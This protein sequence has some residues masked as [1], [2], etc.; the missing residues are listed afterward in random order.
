MPPEL[1]PLKRTEAPLLLVM[2]ELPAVAVDENCTVRASL[3]VALAAVLEPVNPITPPVIAIVPADV[4]LLKK[5][6]LPPLLLL[7]TEVT[8]ERSP[9]LKVMSPVV[10]LVIV[11]A[12]APP[13]TVSEPALTVVPPV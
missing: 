6:P 12:I 10:P 11:P 9:P 8:P 1:L 3:I 7:V 5:A 13:L 4:E 2:V